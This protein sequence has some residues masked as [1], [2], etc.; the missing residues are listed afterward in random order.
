MTPAADKPLPT[1]DEQGNRVQERE[2]FTRLAA[3]TSAA[4]IGGAV[5]FLA[6][7]PVGAVSGVALGATGAWALHRLPTHEVSK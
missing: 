5:G 7:G 4:M 2:A 1:P 6:F 3:N